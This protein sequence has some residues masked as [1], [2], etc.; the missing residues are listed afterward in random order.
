M[1]SPFPFLFAAP[2][3]PC[4]LPAFVPQ[5]GCPPTPAP[6][7]EQKSSPGK[8]PGAALGVLCPCNPVPGQEELGEEGLRT[9]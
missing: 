5:S 7:G 4:P 8:T 9:Q 2:C 6:L 3:F 1:L